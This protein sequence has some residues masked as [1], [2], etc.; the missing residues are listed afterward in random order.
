MVV[1]LLSSTTWPGSPEARPQAPAKHDPVWTADPEKAV[2]PKGA[3]HGKLKGRPFQTA[4][5]TVSGFG[6]L[7]LKQS[8]KGLPPLEVTVFGLIG[9]W[10]EGDS[11]AGK[12]YLITP[13][14]KAKGT[15]E[16]AMKW[17]DKGP[18]LTE[19]RFREGFLLKLEFDK[20]DKEG[21]LPGRLYLCLPDEDKSVVAGTF[22]MSESYPFSPPTPPYIRGRVTLKGTEKGHLE[23]GYIAWQTPPDAKG[24]Q[25]G[26]AGLGSVSAGEKNWSVGSRNTHLISDADGKISFAHL[27]VAPGMHLVYLRWKELYYVWRWV[28]VK[29]NGAVS[30][31]LTV[32]PAQS[33]RLVVSTGKPVE[34]VRLI[35]L[36]ED[37][38]LSPRDLRPKIP[39]QLA[40]IH[41][42]G[43]K[44]GKTVF[45]GLRAARYRV[46]VA[47]ATADVEVKAGKT[48]TVQLKVK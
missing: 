26:G 27:R 19:K 39:D 15:L 30:V 3:A 7:T 14:Q 33:G 23:A 40:L 4:S 45:D 13:K 42:P 8:G 44:D 35:P 38:K 12:R 5:A 21:R 34:A 2:F 17:L 16:V 9:A 10:R 47:T 43:A 37:G 22:L 46:L 29:A 41:L 25:F 36:T 6:W 28:E 31:D 24:G 48:T 20:F 18:F 32:D 11:L 1:C